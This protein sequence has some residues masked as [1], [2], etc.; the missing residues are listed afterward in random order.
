MT[1]NIKITSGKGSF[2]AGQHDCSN[3]IIILELGKSVVDIDHEGIAQGVEGLGSVQGDDADVLLLALLLHQ[4][5]LVFA[6]GTHHCA[7]KP[8]FKNG[9]RG[10]ECSECK[11]ALDESRFR[12]QEK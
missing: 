11:S 4:D 9:G 12:P 1:R 10:M 7:Q 8:A 6:C 2:A 3:R 5:V